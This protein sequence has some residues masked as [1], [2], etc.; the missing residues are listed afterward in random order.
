[1]GTGPIPKVFEFCLIGVIVILEGGAAIS[2]LDDIRGSVGS[3]WVLFLVTG[4][5]LPGCVEFL[6]IDWIVIPWLDIRDMDCVVIPWLVDI[7]GMGC[8]LIP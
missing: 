2:T 8:E 3:I 7:L 6:D 5:E 1:M 4:I